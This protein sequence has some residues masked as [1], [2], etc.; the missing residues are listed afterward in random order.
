M[1]IPRIANAMKYIDDDLIAGAVEYK[2]IPPKKITR[3]WK[4]ITAVAACLVLIL[5]ISLIIPNNETPQISDTD[6]IGAAPAHF[7]FEGNLYSFSGELVYSLP[8]EFKFVSEVNNVGDSF[9]GIDFEGNVD[10]YI[11]MSES[12]KTVAYFQWKEWNEAIDGQEPYLV[13]AL[14]E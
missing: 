3:F 13:L 5:G 6:P 8:E 9:T 12:D 14:T 11:F 10:G 1:S 4:Q 7:Y 2:P